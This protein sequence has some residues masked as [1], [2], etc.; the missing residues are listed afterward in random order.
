MFSIQWAKWALS[1]GIVGIL[2]GPLL[3]WSQ[4]IHDFEAR[5]LILSEYKGGWYNLKT[6][7]TAYKF[8]APYFLGGA[9]LFLTYKIVMDGVHHY[10]HG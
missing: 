8:M 4:Q 10:N 3:T 6:F 1:G 2:L 7:K 5:K 9:A